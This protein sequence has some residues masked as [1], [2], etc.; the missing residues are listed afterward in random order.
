[1]IAEADFNQEG[2]ISF[3]AFKIFMRSEGAGDSPQRKASN[4]QRTSSLRRRPSMSSP[5]SRRKSGLLPVQLRDTSRQI[6]APSPHFSRLQD[7]KKV[8]KGLSDAPEPR[9]WEDSTKNAVDK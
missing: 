3:E 8:K 2:K 5:V 6:G 9:L 7:K 1:M 4:I